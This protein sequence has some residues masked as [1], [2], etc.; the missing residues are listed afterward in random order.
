MGEGGWGREIKKRVIL[1]VAKQPEDPLFVT[2]FAES[3]PPLPFAALRVA[4]G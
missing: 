1:M 2:L 3:G 4:S